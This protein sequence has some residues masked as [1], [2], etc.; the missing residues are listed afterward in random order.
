MTDR[1]TIIERNPVRLIDINAQ[2]AFP[3]MPHQLDPDQLVTHAFDHRFDDF[4]L[5]TRAL[6]HSVSKVSSQ[7][8]K[9]KK[10]PKA[11]F[12]HR[13]EPPACFSWREAAEPVSA[14]PLNNE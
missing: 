8:A 9:T 13:R 12:N 6:F 3:A 2:G 4:P 1:S 7:P 10:G 11:L 14:T 5:F